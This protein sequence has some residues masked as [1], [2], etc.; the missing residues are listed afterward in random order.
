MGI[1]N[2]ECGDNIFIF[3]R[4]PLQPFAA[5]LLCPEISQG[6]A[7][8]IAACGDCDDHLLAFNQ[9]LVHH[10]TGPFDD[11]SAARNGKIF[12]HLAQLI[13]NNPHDPFARR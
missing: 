4:H 11:L 12:F 3:G 8:D 1:G 13:G 9:I 10:I 5:T 6:G 7:L 2:K